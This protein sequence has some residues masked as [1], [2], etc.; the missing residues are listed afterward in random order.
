MSVSGFVEQHKIAVGG[1]ALVGAFVLYLLLR[2]GSSSSSGSPLSTIAAADEQENQV[3][4]AN[5]AQNAQSSAAVQV[6]T[7]QANAQ[8]ATANEQTDAALAA[9]LAQNQTQATQYND[10]TSIANSQT[11]AALD[12]L[13]NTNST[14]LSADTLQTNLEGTELQDSYQLAG[15]QQDETSEEISAVLNDV[16]PGFTGHGIESQDNVTSILETLFGN[17]SGSVAAEQSNLGTETS[18]NLSSASTFNSLI[19]GLTG[20]SSNSSSALS[21]LLA[22]L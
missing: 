17:S 9:A 14:Q 7:V 19:K 3:Q 4:A 8:T 20:T 6:A 22:A 11:N 18:S 12:A 16:A 21:Q 13:E 10:E 15:S 1:V 5:E 2:S